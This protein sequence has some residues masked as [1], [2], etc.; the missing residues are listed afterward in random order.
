MLVFIEGLKKWEWWVLEIICENLPRY[1]QYAISVCDTLQN[2]ITR[3]YHSE[4]FLRPI[5]PVSDDQAAWGLVF[6]LLSRHHFQIDYQKIK[7]FCLSIKQGLRASI[8]IDCL[9]TVS[10]TQGLGQPCSGFQLFWR[11]Y[12]LLGSSPISI[13][14]NGVFYKSAMVKFEAGYHSREASIVTSIYDIKYI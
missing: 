8:D 3:S 6:F 7:I 5:H 9:L 13:L 12:L 14:S 1:S 10:S 4:I 11:Q 2:H